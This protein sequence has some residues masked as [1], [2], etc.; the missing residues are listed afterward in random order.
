LYG[1]FV[2][3]RNAIEFAI[4]Y[5]ECALSVPRYKLPENSVA[6]YEMRCWLPYC[7][8]ELDGDVRILVGRDYKPVGMVQKA[9][10]VDYAQFPLAHVNMSEE[11]AVQYATPDPEHGVGFLYNVSPWSSRAAG[12]RFLLQLRKLLA[13]MVSSEVRP[14]PSRTGQDA[15]T[16]LYVHGDEYEF[17]CAKFFCTICDAMVERDHFERQHPGK[18]ASRYF[19]SLSRW[20]QRPAR[21]RSGMRRPTK[22]V[23]ILAAQ[24]QARRLEE[25]NARG[26]FHRWIEGQQQRSGPVGD[27]ARDIAADRSFP[28]SASS[29]DAIAAYLVRRGAAYEARET[30]VK[31][32][33][34]FEARAAAIE[35]NR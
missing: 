27:L 19:D 34:E 13:W 5:M 21:S 22:P 31:A 1:T 2:S 6:F 12:E 30:L 14:V 15:R 9:D 35:A 24:S 23:N 26:A 18:N 8:H 11:A 4:A 32:W 20:L 33:K 16:R 25:S 7:V 28:G 3:D 29:L 10:H 17:D